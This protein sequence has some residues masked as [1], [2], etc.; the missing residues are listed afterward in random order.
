MSDNQQGP[1]WWQASDGKWYP[2]ESHPNAAV[3]PPSSASTPAPAQT[4]VINKGPGCMKIG[5]IVFAILAVLG[6]GLVGCLALVADEV[7]EEI[8]KATGEAA[9]EDYELVEAECSIDE[10]NMAKASGSIK[11]TSGEAQGF[12]LTV[13][14]ELGDG[15]LLG[16][17]PVFTDTIAVNQSQAWDAIV[18]DQAPDGAT[19]DCQVSKI[20]YT[21]FDDQE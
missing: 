8:D 11:N 2:P 17:S 9:P 20:E 3:A 13:R 7:S 6:I 12:Q 18:L 19:V 5:L 16:E 21:I 10:F 15:S 1:A 4:V 14:F